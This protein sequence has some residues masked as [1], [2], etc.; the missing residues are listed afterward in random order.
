MKKEKVELL[1]KNGGAI[2]LLLFPTILMVAFALH[3]ESIAEFLIFKLKYVPNTAED[4]M[5]T[6]SGANKARLYVAPHLIG[7]FS[8][9][10]MVATGLC[11]G[12]ILF[13]QKPMV[14]AI[15]ASLTLFGALSLSGVFAAWLSFSAV[16]N[17]PSETVESATVV[18]QELTKMQGPLFLISVLSALSLVGLLII[19][20]G[21]FSS[22]ITPKWSSALFSIGNLMIMVFMDLDNWMFIGGLLMLVGMLPVSI[23]LFKNELEF[24]VN[25]CA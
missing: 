18:L 19:G 1:L 3:F 4:F 23:K 2:S 10:F 25:T 11:L 14:S 17:L 15:G 16:G 9:P 12:K 20:I 24:K 21:L 6:L 13:K 22:N 7:Y 5:N 8:V